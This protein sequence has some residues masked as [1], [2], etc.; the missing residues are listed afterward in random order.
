MDLTQYFA[1]TKVRNK[2]VLTVQ[3]GKFKGVGFKYRSAKLTKDL[4]DGGAIMQLDYAV[5]TNPSNL[6]IAGSAAE[7]NFGKFVVE[8]LSRE[9]KHDSGPD[10]A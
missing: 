8:A 6:V 5:V 3:R 9:I 7:K 1:I 10:N 4:P 2:C